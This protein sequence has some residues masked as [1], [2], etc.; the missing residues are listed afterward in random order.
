[1]QWKLEYACV[2]APGADPSRIGLGFEG[3]DEI[4][5]DAQGDLV[6]PA[7]AGP[8]RQRKPVL[9]QDG[10]D[11]GRAVGGGYVLKGADRVGV[12]VAAYDRSRPLVIDPVLVYST[13]LGGSG[14]DFFAG[15]AV[16]G[17]GNAYVTGTTRSADFPTTPGA[18]QLAWRALPDASVTNAVLPDPA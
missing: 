14:D 17:D 3:A 16:D 11:G 4:E 2:L 7:P 6:L 13:Y 8:L 1:M 9:Y 15:I 12:Q 10:A 18:L 5:V